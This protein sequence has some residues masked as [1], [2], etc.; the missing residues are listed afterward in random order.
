MKSFLLYLIIAFTFL[1]V[2]A[3][4]PNEVDK[5]SSQQL[6]SKSESLIDSD[7]MVDNAMVML[8]IIVNRYRISHDD[9][10]SRR[11]ATIALRHLGNLAM[12]RQL[13]YRKAY[14]DLQLAR[15]IAEEDNNKKELSYIYNSL[16][17]LYGL[18]ATSNPTT[19]KRAYEFEFK[20][21]QNALDSYNNDMVPVLAINIAFNQFDNKDWGIFKNEVPKLLIYPYKSKT[22][23]GLIAPKIMNGVNAYFTGDMDKAE[24]CFLTAV[25]MIPKGRYSERLFYI[26]RILLVKFYEVSKQAEK[27][28]AYINSA[29]QE[30]QVREDKEFQLAL[31]NSLTN[32]YSILSQADSVEKYHNQYL[33][34]KEEMEKTAGYL[35]IPTLDFLS[36][37]EET[38]NKLEL[39]SVHKRQTERKNLIMVCCLIVLLVICIC[40]IIIRHKLSHKNKDLYNRYEESLKREK[41]L[42]KLYSTYALPEV[43]KNNEDQNQEA[44]EYEKS[45]SKVMDKENDMTPNE[46]DSEDKSI[47]DIGEEEK[48]QYHETFKRVIYVM[49]HSEEIYKAGFSLN[50]LAKLI[51][52]SSR[53]VSRAINL[54]YGGNYNQFINEYRIREVVRRMHTAE[55]AKCTIEGIAESTGFKSR[56]HFSTIFKKI[57][58]LT[59]AE[60]MRMAQKKT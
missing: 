21:L 9:T 35:S 43:S 44:S 4:N 59:P 15:Q 6:L 37:I 28:L 48:L 20:A 57:T 40:L 55:Y 29:L 23:E 49:E 41:Q 12:T 14:H 52:I 39:L 10:S 19:L 7:T 3:I 22:P 30:S 56:T 1:Q 45:F 46:H 47:N 36:E 25:N 24:N 17:V 8:S 2:Y 60:Y 18:N 33:K 31:L 16:G 11:I 27:S 32:V 26:T 38:N 13:D 51:G 53:T 58:G 42:H 5:L 54:C 34:L 50:H